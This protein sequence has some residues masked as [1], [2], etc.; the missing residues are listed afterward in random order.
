MSSKNL[1]TETLPH[2]RD[3]DLELKVQEDEAMKVMNISI[4]QENTELLSRVVV[5]TQLEAGHLHITIQ[6]LIKSLAC[7]PTASAF[8]SEISVYYLNHAIHSIPSQQPAKPKTSTCQS[9]GKMATEGMIK[10]RSQLAELDLGC[11]TLTV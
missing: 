5:R 1:L 6:F 2:T 8:L 7:G 11:S 3:A 9:Y 4:L 10:T